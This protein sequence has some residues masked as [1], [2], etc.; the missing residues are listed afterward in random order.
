VSALECRLDCAD[1]DIRGAGILKQRLESWK[2]VR[3]AATAP[4]LVEK[5]K[6]VPRAELLQSERRS[7]P[8]ASIQQGTAGSGTARRI[9]T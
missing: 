9:G 7:F 8:L 2:S 5:V 1:P 4:M 6:R 3:V